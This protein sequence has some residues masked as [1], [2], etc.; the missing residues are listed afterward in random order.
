MTL[1]S[2]LKKPASLRLAAALLPLGAMAQTP[3]AP[4]PAA[5]LPT[6]TVQDQAID[7]NPN[8]EVGAPYK[9]RT[10]ADT[11]HTRPLAETP[12][13]IQVIT[14]DAIRDAGATDLKQILQAQPGI[15]LGTGENGNAFGDRYIIRGQEARSDVFV[16]GLR[17]PGMATRES[18]AIEQ[19]EVTKGPNSSFAGR[20][21][22]GGAINAVTKQPTLD[23]DFTRVS[24][25][26]G[27]DS[28]HRVTLDMNK[29]FTDKFALRANAL[30]AGEDVPGRSPSQRRRDGLAL[31]GLWALS[32]DLSVTLDYYGLRAKDKLPDLGGYLVG[33]A[34]H[35]RPATGVPVY[36]QSSDF[37]NS[38][39]DTLTARIAY[40]FAPDLRLTSL[41]RYGESDNR[42]ATTG[43]S[44]RSVYDAAGN[45]AYTAGALDN[46][47]T[48]WQDVK[49]FAHQSNLRWDKQIGGLQHAFIFGFEY[50]DHKVLSGNYGVTNA[51]AYNCRTSATA[52]NNNAWCITDASGN[53]VA[54][55]ADLAGRSIDRR[56]WT[57]DWRVK[58]LALSVMDTVDLTDQW[59]VFGGLRADH[60]DLSLD[61]RNNQTG[62]ITGNY[63][64]SDT[65][66]NG[67]LGVSY[68]INPLGMVYASYGTAQDINGGEP[69]TG[70]SSGYGGLV[71]HN[72]SA[73]GA[74]P[75][76]S[77]NLE[78]GTKWNVL[79]DKLL[80]TA[81]LFQT[82]KDDVMEGADY[83]SL[84]T[85]NT[86]KNRVR[87]LELGLT[88]NVTRNF[89][90]QA[91]VAIMKSKVLR[92]AT[93]ANVGNPLSNFADRS[94]TL[95]GKYQLTPSL[96][97]GAVAR[98]ESSRCGGQPDTGASYSN[99]MCSQPV[100][101][102][103]KYD[104]FA[105]YRINKHAD[106]RLN[107]LNVTDKDYY[108]A[109][110]RSGAF[111][112]KGD[113][114]AVRLTLNLDL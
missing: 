81:A 2:R 23:Y 44:S 112:Y 98:Y 80:A 21:S 96:S 85:F 111:L 38:D 49:Y 25:G 84:G 64:F 51:G 33:T 104:L 93:A 67:H 60:Y 70:T 101:A 107:V 57:R 45:L 42:Y 29:G 36:A 82:T 100:P 14:G 9:A 89:Q 66:L 71:I 3:T 61:T 47:H 10:S 87:G 91:G 35:R 34:P 18:F 105:S 13:T 11:R 74:R 99:G 86:G 69:D 78:L 15:T 114:R 73:A 65:L 110:Y 41:T 17:D 48:G 37:L 62:A 53:P 77:Q 1:S 7:P 12:Q 59:T 97:L 16:D 109:V 20:G 58:T 28:H 46:G 32:Q 5:T 50:T 88:G 63:G 22:A 90:M 4:E 106:L 19:V 108:T 72:G 26:V 68:K 54:G 55:L 94:A 113:G 43:A 31:S 102:F 76:T 95:Q 39:V 56:S 103:S 92:S 40:R 52:A 79:D 75:E 27:T 30:T 6:V 24:A 83:D 8:A